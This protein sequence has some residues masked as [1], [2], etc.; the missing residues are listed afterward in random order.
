MGNSWHR[1]G[2]AKSP[3]SI[4]GDGELHAIGDLNFPG[5]S[6]FMTSWFMPILNMTMGW[7]NNENDEGDDERHPEE[8]HFSRRCGKVLKTPVESGRFLYAFF[9]HAFHNHPLNGD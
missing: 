3:A 9:S 1:I 8:Q 2:L 5:V 4:S 6:H 7:I